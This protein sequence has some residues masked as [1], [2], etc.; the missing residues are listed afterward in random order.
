MMSKSADISFKAVLQHG[1]RGRTD[2]EKRFDAIVESCVFKTHEHAQMPAPK[3]VAKQKGVRL[4]TV[5]TMSGSARYG[6]TRTVTVCDNFQRAKEII[7]KNEGD[8]FETTYQLAVIDTIVA[9]WLYYVIDEQ[10]WFCWVGDA[11]DG[12][13]KAIER[14]A[15][16]ENMIGV[17]GVG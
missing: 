16:Y 13:Y 14:P 10:Y 5:T 3:E 6:G 15:A 17:G 8:L 11:K 7:E 12:C 9:G 4:Y 2:E 1:L